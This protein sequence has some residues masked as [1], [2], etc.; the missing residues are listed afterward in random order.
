MEK[1]DSQKISDWIT[2]FIKDN[3]AL[4]VHEDE[5][6]AR[7]KIELQILECKVVAL[8]CRKRRFRKRDNGLSPKNKPR[9]RAN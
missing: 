6:V 4:V 5:D 7:L 2:G 1:Q 9:V 8:Q 3:M